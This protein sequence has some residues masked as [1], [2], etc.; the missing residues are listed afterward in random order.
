MSDKKQT[1]IDY[2]LSKLIEETIITPKDKKVDLLTAIKSFRNIVD[3]AKQM[4]KEQIIEAHKQ[5]NKNN[6][7][8]LRHEHEQYYNETYNTNQ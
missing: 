4:E 3:K 5:G 6:G 7:W 2:F 1:A 8:A